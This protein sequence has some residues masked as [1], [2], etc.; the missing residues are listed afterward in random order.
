M[1]SFKL[2]YGLVILHHGRIR[3]ATVSVDEVPLVYISVPSTKDPDFLRRHPGRATF[4]E[5]TF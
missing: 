3:L 5:G 2:L 4:F 1:I